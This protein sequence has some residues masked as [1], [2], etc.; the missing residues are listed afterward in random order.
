MAGFDK[1]YFVG[2]G[3]EIDHYR[4]HYPVPTVTLT[5]RLYHDEQE[6]NVSR[7]LKITEELLTFAY[8]DR[9]KQE[10]LS[11]KIT[12]ETGDITAF[13]A[14]TVRYSDIRAV[15]INPGTAP[16]SGQAGFQS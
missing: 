16:G 5:I 13:P 3:A 12:A 2:I 14:L 7:V 8:F 15:E 9:K 10:R 6:F 1:D 11:K 4:K